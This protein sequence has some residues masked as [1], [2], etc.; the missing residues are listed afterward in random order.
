MVSLRAALKEPV[1]FHD[2]FQ[3]ERGT[4]IVFPA[5]SVHFDPENYQD[6]QKFNGFR[7]AG[8][9]PCT[10]NSGQLPQGSGRLKADTVDEKY[11]PYVT[12]S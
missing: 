8:D 5:Q 7:F 12:S 11:L 2:G 6:P 3:L 10:C 9:G 4:R 1:T